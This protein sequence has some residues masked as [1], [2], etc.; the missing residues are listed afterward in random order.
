MREFERILGVSLELAEVDLAE[1]QAV[2]TEEV[3][4]AKAALAFAKVGDPVIV[5]DTGFELAAL[6]GFPG[7]LVT[8]VLEAGGLELLHRML[9]AESAPI[10]TAV[11]CIGLADENGVQIFTGRVTGTVLSTPRGI[12]GFGFDPVFVPD[13]ETSSLAEMKD[14]DKDR[15]SPRG[16]ALAKLAEFLGQRLAR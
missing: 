12:G 3:C 15:H 14:A 10:A 13:G 7:A 2:D 16:L 5:D 9:P 8:W 6:R 1:I 4:R 11:T